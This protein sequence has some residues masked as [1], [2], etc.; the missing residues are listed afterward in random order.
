MPELMGGMDEEFDGNDEDDGKYGG[1][2]AEV[3]KTFSCG[4]MQG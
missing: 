4:P 1:C 2:V 3:V